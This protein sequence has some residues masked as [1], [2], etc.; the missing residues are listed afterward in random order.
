MRCANALLV[1]VDNLLGPTAIARFVWA[2][3]RLTS[4]RGEWRDDPLSNHLSGGLLVDRGDGYD[5]MMYWEG[6]F[7]MG[8][9][10]FGI[11]VCT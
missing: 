5:G 1:A 11:P 6:W 10:V 9:I 7:W 2:G 8:S 4:P 3:G